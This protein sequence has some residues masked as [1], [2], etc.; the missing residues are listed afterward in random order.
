MKTNRVLYSEIIGEL[1]ATG[2]DSWI[3]SKFVLEKARDITNNFTS[4][5]NNSNQNIYKIPEG[6]KEATCLPLMEVSVTTC[7]LG[8][9][10]CQKLMRTKEKIPS[11]FSGKYGALI[12]SVASENFESFYEF[13]TP[14]GWKAAQKRRDKSGKKYFFFIGGYL[15]IPIPKGTQASPEVLRIE[16]YFSKPWEVDALN[17]KGC[18]DCKEECLKPLD[19]DFVAPNY[20]LDD[21]K[22]EVTRQLSGIYLKIQRDD[23]P[24]ISQLQRGSSNQ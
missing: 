21:I 4:K 20:I 12:K 17:K 14:K 23:Y 5:D 8:T 13:T 6:W 9:A 19:Y 11:I 10:Y 22:K 16:A 2:I 15:F 1:K 18:V 3:S 24:D 7:D